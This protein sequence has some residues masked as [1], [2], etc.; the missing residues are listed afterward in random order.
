MKKRTSFVSNSSSSSFIC[1]ACGEEGYLEGNHVHG[2]AMC[3]NGHHFCL[4]CAVN[5]D[6]PSS[7]SEREHSPYSSFQDFLDKEHDY[8]SVPELYCPACQFVKPPD[9]EILEYLI[10]KHYSG[11]REV[12]LDELKKKFRTYSKFLEMINRNTRGSFLSRLL[13]PFNR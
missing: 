9:S 10:Q 12:L 3:E 11:N 4:E 13:K 1:V 8:N 2:M 7:D 5:A 6:K